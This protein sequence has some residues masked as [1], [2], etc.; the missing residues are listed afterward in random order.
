M[1]YTTNLSAYSLSGPSGRKPFDVRDILPRSIIVGDRHR[2]LD[3]EKVKELAQSFQDHSQKQPIGVRVKTQPDRTVRYEL[4]YGLHRLEAV[5]LLEREGR[6]IEPMIWAIIYPENYPDIAAQMDELVENLHR[7]ELT[8]AER[9]AQ[10]AVY[11]GLLKKDHKAQTA[12]KNRSV[13]AKNQHTPKEEGQPQ[14]AVHPAKLPT[15]TEKIAAD[16][17]I[18]KDTVHRRHANAVKLAEREGVV[19]DP[20]ERSLEKMSPDKLIEVGKAATRAASKKIEKAKALGKHE[21][22][23][24]PV[25]PQKPTERTVTL[26]VVNLP[27]TLEKWC[28]RRLNDKSLS[29][30]VLEKTVDMLTSLLNDVS[31]YK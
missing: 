21:S 28:R 4:L 1:P 24:D 20:A 13:N 18:D 6:E 15:I 11:A 16:L 5:R 30:P 22:L 19:I 14:P 31:I 25:E 3:Q 9:S 8:S 29:I 2:P 10:G 12:N 17:G 26:D 27:Q 23:V 7:K